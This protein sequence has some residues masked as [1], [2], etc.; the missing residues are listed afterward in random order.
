MIQGWIR[1]LVVFPIRIYQRLIS[2]VLS[3]LFA[4]KCRYDPSCSE[5]MAQAVHEWGVFRGIWI[6]IKRIGRCHP[7]GGFGPD[8]I[9]KRGHKKE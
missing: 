3:G 8:P 9:P 1:T 4:M 6:G 2:P 5:Y 7:W